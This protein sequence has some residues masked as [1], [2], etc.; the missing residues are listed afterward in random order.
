MVLNNTILVG[1]GLLI[2]LYI[3]YK[4]FFGRNQLDKDFEKTYQEILTSDKHKA[5]GQYEK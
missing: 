1:L 4:L 2:A 5:K 3:L